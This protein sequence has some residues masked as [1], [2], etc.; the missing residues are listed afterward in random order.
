VKHKNITGRQLRHGAPEEQLAPGQSLLIEKRSGKRFQLTRVDAGSVD[1]NAQMD[2]IFKEIPPEGPRPK[3]D[4]A[5][6]L[7]EERE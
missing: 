3:T 5:R 4:L 6:I 2:R 7:L 1:F